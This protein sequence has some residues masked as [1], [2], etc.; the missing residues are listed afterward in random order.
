MY[1]KARLFF[2]TF[3]LYT[4]QLFGTVVIKAD[5]HLVNGVDLVQVVEDKVENRGPSRGRPIQLTSFVDLERGLLGLA[6]LK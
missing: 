1:Q 4:V 5:W 6:N 2:Y 3:T